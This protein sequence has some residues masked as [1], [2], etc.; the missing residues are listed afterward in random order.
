MP[1]TATLTK[2]SP[3]TPGNTDLCIY[4]HYRIFHNETLKEKKKN[5]EAAFL[6]EK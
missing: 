2:P 4:C 3:P 5:T 1:P 6:E